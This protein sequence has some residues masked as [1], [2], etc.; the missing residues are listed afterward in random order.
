MRGNAIAERW[1]ASARH[2][3]LDRMLI[4][5]ERR[6]QFMTGF[7]APT[8]RLAGESAVAEDMV[9]VRPE[10]HRGLGANSPSA[11]PASVTGQFAVKLGRW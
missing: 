8:G 1:I 4:T 10:G 9:E 3:C 5:S 7:P 2:E 11:Q 6:L